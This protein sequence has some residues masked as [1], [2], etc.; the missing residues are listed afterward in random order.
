[1]DSLEEVK[2]SVYNST[3]STLYANEFKEFVVLQFR[4]MNA[5]IF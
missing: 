5:I 2:L 4:M 1:M 3:K